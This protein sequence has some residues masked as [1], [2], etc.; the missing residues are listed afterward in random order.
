MIDLDAFVYGILLLI[1]LL[2]A[3]CGIGTV[4]DSPSHCEDT[5]CP[6]APSNTTGEV[7]YGTFHC[8][9]ERGVLIR[10]SQ[11]RPSAVILDCESGRVLER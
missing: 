9:Y 8:T 11:T 10:V 2:S 1:L 3:V 7:H 5:G 6:I 4:V